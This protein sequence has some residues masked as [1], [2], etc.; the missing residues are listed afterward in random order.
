MATEDTP[1]HHF[2]EDDLLDLSINEEQHETFNDLTLIGSI[3]SDRVLNFRAVKAIL[4]SA[5]NLG[6]FIQITALNRNLIACIFTRAADRDRI[7]NSGPWAVKGHIIS[8]SSCSPNVSLEEID[9]S[10]FGFKY[11]TYLP[12][13]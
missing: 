13:E 11:I 12:I 6:P 10:C 2:L 3:V 8:F 4:L 7:L 9:F 1:T 5:W